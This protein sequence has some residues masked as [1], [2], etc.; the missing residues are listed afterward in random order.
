MS[1]NLKIF[2][3]GGSRGNPGP[4][5]SGFAV[6]KKG[7]VIHKGSKY[8]GKSTNNVAEYTAVV[9]ALEW[10]SKQNTQSIDT[11]SFVLDSELVTKQLNG[12]Y[13]IK[14]ENLRKLAIRIKNLETKIKTRIT[15][16]WSPRSENKV[17]DSLVNIAL[18]E[19]M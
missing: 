18:D 13:K 12:L 2:C 14:N 6:Y 7:E 10:L 19:N 11:V 5:A 1:N 4:A 17:A 15:Y 8:L 9:L 16:T 3:D